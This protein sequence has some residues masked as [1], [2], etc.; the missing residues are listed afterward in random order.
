MKNEF[1]LALEELR[2]FLLEYNLKTLSANEKLQDELRKT[3]K[4]YYPL[5]IWSNLITSAS[6]W[7][8]DTEKSAL[9]QL[10]AV[11][12]ASDLCYSMFLSFQGMYKP[13]LVQLRC[14]LENF[15]RCV[16]IVHDEPISTKSVVELLK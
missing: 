16:A 9:F 13:A 4:R 14:G 5:L 15:F 2:G 8:G 1:K 12:V 3:F 10:Y 7:K 6:I 11:E